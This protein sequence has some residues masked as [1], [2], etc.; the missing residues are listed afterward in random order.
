MTTKD[1]IETT[2]DGSIIL[3]SYAHATDGW[4]F[5]DNEY[6]VLIFQSENKMLGMEFNIFIGWNDPQP[7]A[8]LNPSSSHTFTEA[9]N[10]YDVADMIDEFRAW[11]KDCAAAFDWIQ[12]VDAEKGID[13]LTM[14]ESRHHDTPEIP[15]KTE[16]E[17]AD[18]LPFVWADAGMDC[19]VNGDVNTSV[20]EYTGGVGLGDLGACAV[21]KRRYFTRT[22][23][24]LGTAEETFRLDSTDGEI[25]AAGAFRVAAAIA[26]AVVGMDNNKPT[27]KPETVDNL[28]GRISAAAHEALC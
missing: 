6:G 8:E 26:L 9:E 7:H 16:D 1:M 24:A 12:T 21:T 28:A 15:V 17:E 13:V 19:T 27:A 2:A 11:L 25:P 10:I 22:G 14:R 20:Y 18:V 23:D 4:K 3:P 5:T